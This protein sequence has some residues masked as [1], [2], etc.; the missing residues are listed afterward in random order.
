MKIGDKVKLSTQFVATLAVDVQP[1]AAALRGVITQ[2]DPKEHDDIMVWN[3]QWNATES[4][5]QALGIDD[6]WSAKYGW[7]IE[8]CWHL[9]KNL[10]VVS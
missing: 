4:E 3:V 1:K 7:N 5:L 8:E 10:E 6:E 2:Y 9:T